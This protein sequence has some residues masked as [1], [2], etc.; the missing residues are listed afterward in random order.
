L[1]AWLGEYAGGIVLMIGTP[2]WLQS[3]AGALASVIPA[4]ILVPRIFFEERFL[5]RELNG[6]EAYTRK[7]PLQARPS[8]LVRKGQVSSSWVLCGQS[9]KD[10]GE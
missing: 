10:G 8:C 2:L 1:V 4:T 5:R 6:Y 7:S 9:Q 3:Y